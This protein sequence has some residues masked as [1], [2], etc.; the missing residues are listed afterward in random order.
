MKG[1]M[2][3]SSHGRGECGAWLIPISVDYRAA[4]SW[5]KAS[6][7]Y[8][9]YDLPTREPP[10]PARSYPLRVPQPSKVALGPMLGIKC[11]KTPACG[12]DYLLKPEE[13]KN[14]SEMM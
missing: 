13:R 12:A 8:N 14:A 7:D 11:S 6:L 3:A 10:S 4:E 5:W 9:P 2:V 1:F